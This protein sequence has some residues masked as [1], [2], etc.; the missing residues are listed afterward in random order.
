MEN[1]A[2]GVVLDHSDDEPKHITGNYVDGKFIEKG[3]YDEVYTKAIDLGRKS[4]EA[5]LHKKAELKMKF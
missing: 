5:F 1:V 2:D 3:I 4:A